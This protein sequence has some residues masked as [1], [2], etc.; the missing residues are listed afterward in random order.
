M[1]KRK[2]VTI[3][4]IIVVSIIILY[5][6]SNYFNRHLECL[7]HK[8]VPEGYFKD[9][10]YAEF[11]TEVREQEI[12][13]LINESGLS[14]GNLHID[15]DIYYIS[16]EDSIKLAGLFSSVPEVKSVERNGL[17]VSIEFYK[18]VNPSESKKVVEDI[19]EKNNILVKH[20]D[21]SEIGLK[22]RSSA[23][24]EIPSESKFNAM[25]WVCKFRKDKIVKDARLQSLRINF[26]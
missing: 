10:F 6:L 1:N 18:Y 8:E 22:R 12:V 4:L 21:Y 13:K 19:V 9:R 17:V 2:I 23:Y 3:F 7:F 16:S 11:N 20:S 25:E 14:T 24:I 26:A 5:F 15:G